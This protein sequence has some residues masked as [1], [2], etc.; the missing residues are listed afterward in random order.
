MRRVRGLTAF[1]AAGLTATLALA[2]CAGE[3]GNGDDGTPSWDAC[4]DDPNG[5][6]SGE[7]AA[8]GEVTWGFEQEQ[9]S[10]NVNTSTGNTF[11]LTQMMDKLLVDT[12]DFQPDGTWAWDLDL[13]AEEPTLTSEEPQSWT[14]Q[15][16]PEAK[17]NDGT[18]ITAEDFTF[19]WKH[20]SGNT[21]VCPACDPPS[22]AGFEVID[23]I[24]GSDNGKTVTVTLQPGAKFAE[25][26]FLFTD[27]YP[28]HI[29]AQQGDLNTP[30]GMQAASDY[31][32]ETQPT[33]SGGPYQVVQADLSQQIILEPNPGWYGEAP[34]LETVTYRIVTEQDALVTAMSSGEI[35]G[36]GAQPNPDMVQQIDAM[37]GVLSHVGAGYEWEHIDLNVE[38]QWLADPE[39]RKAIF[40][41]IDVN[42]INERTFASFFP[43]VSQKTNHLFLADDPNFQDHITGTGQGTG[44]EAAALDILTAA[45]YTME[46]DQLTLDGQ[47]VGPLRFVHTEGNALRATTAQLVQQDLA[48]LGIEVT[49]ETTADLGGTLVEGDFDLM[50][51]A[52]VGNP[53]FQTSGDQ[54]WHSESDS[55]YMSYSNPEVD[56]LVK[57]ALNQIDLAVVA[58]LLNQANALVVQDAVSLPIAD[59]PVYAFVRD[60]YL[61]VRP[62]FTNA[63][64]PY[65][66]NQWGTTAAAE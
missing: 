39:L 1:A 7:V 55:N 13:L 27:L 31:F 24:E 37:G 54:F 26:Q 4:V 5:C 2:A 21:D 29:A 58:D 18:D 14:Y 65:N 45:G 60:T 32:S 17:W 43:E 38:N 48:E 51:F 35:D 11:E 64:T 6:N 49:I 34:L 41:A 62:N 10:W 22:S 12:G 33:Y 19:L 23:T 44:D 61:N 47:P 52:W 46:G 53:A 15:I 40:T 30:E 36:S 3:Q 66:V 20:N 8:G 57:D 16:R 63:G 56:R 59:K 28:A 9:A 25:W 42:N 50:I